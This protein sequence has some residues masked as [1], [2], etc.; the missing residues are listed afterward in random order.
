MDQ[1]RERDYTPDE[2]GRVI[3]YGPGDRPLCGNDA[4]TAVYT[5]DQ[6]WWPAAANAW[7]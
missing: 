3:H 4:V 7:S 6:P 5:D 2:Y 1:G